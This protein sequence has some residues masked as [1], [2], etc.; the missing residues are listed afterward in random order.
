ML[1]SETATSLEARVQALLRT[2]RREFLGWM[3]VFWAVPMFSLYAF[4]WSVGWVIRGFKQ[5]KTG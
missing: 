4:G 1:V 3:A 5:R 2:R